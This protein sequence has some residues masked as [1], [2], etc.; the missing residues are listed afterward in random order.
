[1]KVAIEEGTV[2]LFPEDE[3]DRTLG[4]VLR[5]L[6]NHVFAI[7]LR[8]E[9]CGDPINITRSVDPR[10]AA[11]SNLAATPFLLDDDRANINRR[12][13][14]RRLAERTHRRHESRVRR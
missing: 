13:T 10:Y 9:V 14:S 2:R 4:I 6:R 8:E 1:M 11:I 3:S 5:K 7:G 12:S